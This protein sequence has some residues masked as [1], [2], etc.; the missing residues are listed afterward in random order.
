MRREFCAPNCDHLIFF[1]SILGDSAPK[2]ESNKDQP[3]E[4][5]LSAVTTDAVVCDY[6]HRAAPTRRCIKRHPK[7]MKKLFCNESCEELAHRKKEAP[8]NTA[9]KP[10][11]KKKK[12]KG[13]KDH[14][15]EPSAAF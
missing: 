13:K 12:A 1:I 9:K 6:C 8:A 5:D 14:I 11:P 7:C 3:P 2:E 4:N 10:D 15:F